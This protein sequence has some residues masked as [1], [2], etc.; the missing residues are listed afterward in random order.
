MPGEFLRKTVRTQAAERLGGVVI[1]NERCN[2]VALSHFLLKQKVGLGDRVVDATCGNGHD[3]L[4]LAQLVGPA[5]RVWGFDIQ[6]RALAATEC[7]LAG[8]GCRDRVELLEAGHERI[9][10]LV[11][12]PLAAVIFNLGY[13][14]GGDRQIVTRPET[15]LQ[16]LSSAA[17]MLLPRGLLLAVVYTGHAGGAEEGDVVEQWAADVASDRFCVWTCRRPNRHATSPWLLVVEKGTR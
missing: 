15:T 12:E 11:P 8:H 1:G 4:F 3:T 13:L 14:P 7:L 10:D 2:A 9:G 5:G 6:R 17:D 16:A